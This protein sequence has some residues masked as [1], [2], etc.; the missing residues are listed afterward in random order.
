MQS[1]NN[2]GSALLSALFLMT[3]VAIAATAMSMRLQ[4][5][6]YRTN[7]SLQ[8][9]KLY[10]S[11]EAVSFWAI[12]ELLDANKHFTASD[13]QGKVANFP[14]QMAGL[15]PGIQIRGALYDLQGKFNLNNLT[16]QNY[17]PLFLRL[18]NGLGTKLP[19]NDQEKIVIA[20]RQWVS[21]Y[22]PGRGSDAFINY[23]WQQ[24][25]PYYPS[26]QLLQSV[27]EFRLVLGVSAK[28]YEIAIPYI[29]VL[30]D[31][32]PININTAPK[33][34][35]MALGGGLSEANA[36]EIITARGQHGITDLTEL[37]ILLDKMHIRR[38]QVTIDSQF[39][40]SVAEVS[41][42]TSRLISYVV[43][44][45][46]KEDKKLSVSVVSQSLNVM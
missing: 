20:T 45:R 5:D 34:V 30:P 13:D 11:T 22:S 31:T 4:L 44:K 10:L 12:G 21:P 2:K 33:K 41:N 37:S 26:N 32:T 38:D 46:G 9:D 7:L 43:L 28:I 23:Y 39:F 3:L 29:V 35:L 19:V 16:D 6:I 17:Y 27:S 36:E 25:P 18:I 8:S 24:K 14:K 42:G 1:S 15:S 40:L